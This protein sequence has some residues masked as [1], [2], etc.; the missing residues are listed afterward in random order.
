MNAPSTTIRDAGVACWQCGAASRGEYFCPACGKIQP[1]PR[2]ATYFDLFGMPP[3][4]GI[5]S[6]ALES[7]FHKLSWKLHPDNFTHATEFERNLSLQR[8]SE[9]NDAYRALREPISR[10]EYLLAQRGMRREGAAKQKAPPELLEEV[11]ELN[12]WLDQ[13][14]ENRAAASGAAPAELLQRLHHAR[15]NFQEKLGS[16]DAE[17]EKVCREWDRAIAATGGPAAQEDPTQ[18]AILNR[19]NEILNRRSY[20]RNLVAGVQTELAGP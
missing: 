14:R 2:G 11:F 13:L 19:L 1:L 20:I 10:V 9:L 18:Q 17:L 15:D 5:E 4:L 6:A 12:E 7:R 16:V 8:C 3:Q